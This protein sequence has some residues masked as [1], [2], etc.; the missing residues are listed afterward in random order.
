MEDVMRGRNGMA[1]WVA[2][3]GAVGASA[4]AACQSER[5]VAPT[6]GHGAHEATS[7]SA[8]QADATMLARKGDIG[9]GRWLAIGR[10]DG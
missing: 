10:E 3:A 2:V 4:F 9:V 5:N 6:S 7:I 1:S 8:A